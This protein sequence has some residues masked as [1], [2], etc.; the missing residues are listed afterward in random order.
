VTT[1]SGGAAS[2]GNDNFDQAVG[3]DAMGTQGTLEDPSVDADF[4]T[5]DA[6]AGDIY[7]ISASSHPSASDTTAGYIDTFI[8][9]YDGNK[10]LLATNDDRYPRSNTDSEIIT[11]LPTTGTY[12]VKLQEFCISPKKDAMACDATYFAGLTNLDYVVG[13][14]KIDPTQA[15]NVSEKEPNDTGATASPIAFAQQTTMGSYYLTIIEGKMPMSSD[16]DWYSF[17]VPANLTVTAGARAKTGLLFPWGTPTSN[18]TNV[19]MGKVDVVDKATMKVVGS[20]DM[21]AEPETQ[22]DRTDL[23]I[24]VTAGGDYLLKVTHGGLEADGQGEFYF[25]YQTLGSGNPLEKAEAA[26]D[27]ASTPEVLTVSAGSTSTSYFVE[28][29]ITPGD[30][31]HFKVATK[32]QATVSVACSAQRG[33]SGLRGFKAT[34]FSGKDGTTKITEATETATTD[35]FIDHFAVPT[36]ETDLIV[37]MEATG[38]QDPVNT[39]TYYICGIHMAAVPTP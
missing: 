9:L 2:D 36:G 35:L 39:G 38:T 32:A 24:P 31:D 30:V 22:A 26:N 11:V 10:K 19:K 20:F 13:A 23:S 16:A 27:L 37:K 7:L 3:I 33:G 4:Y 25:V 14:I 21:S 5:F 6:S 17:T 29:D 12:Y 8:E 34:V 28:G 15:G 18:G 1:G